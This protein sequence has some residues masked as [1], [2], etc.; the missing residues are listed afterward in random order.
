MSPECQAIVNKTKSATC[1]C[2]KSDLAP[3]ADYLNQQFMSCTSG[4]PRPNKNSGK[5]NFADGLIR[6]VCNDF[7]NDDP[8]SKPFQIG[9][10]SIGRD[11]ANENKQN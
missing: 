11:K 1:D 7:N 2:A 4:T 6:M 5:R 3:K 9:G 8:C 10:G